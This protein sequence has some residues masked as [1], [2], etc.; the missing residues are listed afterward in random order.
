MRYPGLIRE[1]TK[2]E[3]KEVVRSTESTKEFVY[4]V[5]KEIIVCD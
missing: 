5:L 3:A 1:S 2:E 4:K